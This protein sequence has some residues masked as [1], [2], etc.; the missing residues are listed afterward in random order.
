MGEWEF[1]RMPGRGV[2]GPPFVWSWRCLSEDGTIRS[3]PDKFRFFL[4]CVAHARLHGYDYRPL[5]TRREFA[6]RATQRKRAPAMGAGSRPD[7][8]AGDS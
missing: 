1:Y 3:A 4:D 6:Y 7:R 2:E 8:I 5:L